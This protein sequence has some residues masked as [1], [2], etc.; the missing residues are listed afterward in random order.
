MRDRQF[1][2]G[3]AAPA[4]G[5]PVQPGLEEQPGHLELG[6]P[7]GVVQGRRAVIPVLRDPGPT[8]SACWH[9]SL[10]QSHWNACQPERAAAAGGTHWL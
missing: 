1:P 2:G 5:G 7:C 6:V 4:L 10:P 9:H 8:L 3:L